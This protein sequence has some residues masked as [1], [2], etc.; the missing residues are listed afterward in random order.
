MARTSTILAERPTRK[1]PA[2]TMAAGWR[3]LLA[4]FKRDQAVQA[5][6]QEFTAL[7]AAPRQPIV[8]SGLSG[9]ASV[10]FLRVLAETLSLPSSSSNRHII[11][12]L[13]PTQAESETCYQELS[14]VQTALHSAQP[15]S[16]RSIVNAWYPLSTSMAAAPQQQATFHNSQ[17]RLQQY[18]RARSEFLLTADRQNNTAEVIIVSAVEAALNN[19]AENSPT[20]PV[21]PK[22]TPAKQ[23]KQQPPQ[24]LLLEQGA[25]Y[26]RDALLSQLSTWGYTRQTD[27]HAPGE[28]A[29]RGE[30]VELFAPSCERPVCLYFFGDELERIQLLAAPTTPTTTTT[31]TS[32]AIHSGSAARAQTSHPAAAPVTLKRVIITPFITADSPAAA[33]LAQRILPTQGTQI[34]SLSFSELAQPLTAAKTVKLAIAPAQH[35]HQKLQQFTNIVARELAGGRHVYIFAANPLL[36]KSIHQLLDKFPV[37]QLPGENN[38]SEVPAAAQQPTAQQQPGIT[39]I[40]SSFTPTSGFMSSYCSLFTSNEIFGKRLLRRSATASTAPQNFWETFLALEEDDYIVHIHHGIGIYRGIEQIKIDDRE[41]AY[42]KLEYRDSAKLFVPIEQ[43][44]LV[45]KYIGDRSQVRMS[46]LG[47]AQWQQTKTRSQKT[48]AGM[49]KKLLT[50]YS[51]RQALRVSPLAEETYFQE[52]F[53]LAFPYTESPAQLQAC[54]EVKADLAQARPM[55]R[56]LCADVGYGK[57]EV[58]LRGIF[59]VAMAGRQ[60][61]FLVPTTLLSIQHFQTFTQRFANTPLSCAI[62]NRFTNKQ[63]EIDILRKL[64]SGALSVLIATHKALH[65]KVKF[66]RLAFLIIDEEQKFGVAQKEVLRKTYPAVHTLSLSATPIPRTLHLALSSLRDLSFINTPIAGRLPVQTAVMETN[67]AVI[68][69]AVARERARGGQCYVIYN[70]VQTLDSFAARLKTLIPNASILSIHAQLPQTEIE[71]RFLAFNRGAYD[72]L[73]AT[74]IIDAGLDIPR[75]N[76]LF[77]IDAQRFGLAQLY[78]LKGRVGRSAAAAYAYFFYPAQTS[79]APAARE[80]LSCLTRYTELGAGY[81]IAV[82]DLELR[83]AGN[84]LGIEQAGMLASVGLELF[85]KLLQE[86]LHQLK[87]GKNAVPIYYEPLIELSYKGFISDAI[88][89]GH[90]RKAGLYRDIITAKS[91]R[92]LSGVRTKLQNE[93]GALPLELENLFKLS[94]FKLFAKRVYVKTIIEKNEHVDIEFLEVAKLNHQAL[95]L[96]IRERRVT[97]LQ[98]RAEPAAEKPINTEATMGKQVPAALAQLQTALKNTGSTP[99]M[100]DHENANKKPTETK[101]RYDLRPHKMD[102]RPVP[103]QQ[104][105]KLLQDLI[106]TLTS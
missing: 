57:T 11:L 85:S 89:P 15:T 74:S 102:F 87:H 14:Q 13:N 42:L 9:F 63:E 100:A 3:M 38:P 50:L 49:A 93:H 22:L 47:K 45:Q 39:L 71:T 43:L 67:I 34:W 7:S 95:H 86:A 25:C 105:L 82:K 88:A 75:V 31:T 90:A 70:R 1:Q 99:P 97:V 68:Q 17:E 56:L 76:T 58:A 83:G 101:L 51:Q 69:T 33:P 20:S 37:Q 44:Q 35:F 40:T 55:D 61:L 77:V 62:L 54:E 19:T 96:F 81:Q 10:L 106:T 103:L 18:H 65:K 24:Q 98:E 60:C 48:A 12:V 41:K 53:E 91:L 79:L 6:L 26:E 59:K 29:Q 28:M 27:V 84:L 23:P 66:Q 72:V 78:Q 52:Q 16:T 64:K 30:L 73:V 92:A 80:R 104:K 36:S 46:A 32:A 5:A 8:I 2:Q 94:A 21:P 4:Q